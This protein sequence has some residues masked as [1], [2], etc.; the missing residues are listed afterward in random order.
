MECA[1]SASTSGSSSTRSQRQGSTSSRNSGRPPG[2]AASTSGNT[3]RNWSRKL[4]TTDVAASPMSRGGQTLGSPNKATARNGQ[5]PEARDGPHEVVGDVDNAPP[6]IEHE[7]PVAGVVQRLPCELRAAG[8]QEAGKTQSVRSRNRSG[9]PISS[10]EPQTTYAY[11][12]R[13]PLGRP[14]GAL[15]S[16]RGSGWSNLGRLCMWRRT[17]RPPRHRPRTRSRS[18]PSGCGATSPVRGS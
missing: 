8:H 13:R 2:D 12:A 1:G 5:F 10:V 11:P 9:T 17:R 7:A 18:E 3:L 15:L 16:S 14:S 4:A 6:R